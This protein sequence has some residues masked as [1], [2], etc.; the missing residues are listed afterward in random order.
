MEALGG[1]SGISKSE[2]SLICESL[3]EQVKPFLQRQLDHAHFPY[4]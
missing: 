1:A 4:A 3:D 2:K